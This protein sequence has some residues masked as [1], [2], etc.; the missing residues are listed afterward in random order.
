[1]SFQHFLSTSGFVCIEESPSWTKGYIWAEKLLL[2]ICGCHWKRVTLSLHRAQHVL[3]Q[4]WLS[5]EL[6][7]ALS[8][9]KTSGFAK[10]QHS[11][12]SLQRMLFKVRSGL[13]IRQFS[14]EEQLLIPWICFLNG[15]LK[16]ALF[17][18]FFLRQHSNKIQTFYLEQEL[19]ILL[20]LELFSDLLSSFLLK[21]HGKH[22]SI[23]FWGYKFIT[24]KIGFAVEDN[25]SK[26][27]PPPLVSNVL[28]AFC[29]NL[30]RFSCLK[31]TMKLKFPDLKVPE[32]CCGFRFWIPYSEH[33]E[34]K[35]WWDEIM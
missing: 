4:A 22:T 6:T 23:M 9:H 2:C 26:L 35:S 34:S 3:G 30:L 27:L 17:F 1:M 18:F 25:L 12:L 13:M 8:G 16:I 31:F 24:T 33:E 20:F 32:F 5:W 21:L 15:V 10:G 28:Q 11:F 7:T 19:S 14:L 29:E